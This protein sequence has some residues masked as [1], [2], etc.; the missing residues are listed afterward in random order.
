MG[1]FTVLPG[2][3]DGKPLYFVYEPRT[4]YVA[5]IV[6]FVDIA[7]EDGSHFSLPKILFSSLV[8]W[9]QK[10]ERQAGCL[11]SLEYLN[12]RFDSPPYFTLLLLT[13]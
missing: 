3:F 9:N 8:G 13:S 12:Q 10:R 4:L 1:A 7:G 11:F 5:V 6:S 2:L